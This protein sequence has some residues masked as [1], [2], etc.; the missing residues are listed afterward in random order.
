MA[1]RHRARDGHPVVALRR[2][3]SAWG[4]SRPV[5]RGRREH[6]DWDRIR[7]AGHAATATVAPA[8]SR[9]PLPAGATRGR[10]GGPAA[11]LEPDR[12]GELEALALPLD[13]LRLGLCVAG[14]VA[15]LR[16]FQPLL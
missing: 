1:S 12:A 4:E 11:L 15:L 3:H 2:I 8:F 13:L 7:L 5:A 6:G 10:T 16:R 14:G 9:A